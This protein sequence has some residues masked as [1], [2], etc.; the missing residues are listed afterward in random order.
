VLLTLCEV[1]RACSASSS[2][3]PYALA[4]HKHASNLGHHLL[5]SIPILPCKY[6]S[7]CFSL[8]RG[9]DAC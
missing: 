1:H 2:A 6:L 5:V 3:L 7:G 4:C 8:S 9:N